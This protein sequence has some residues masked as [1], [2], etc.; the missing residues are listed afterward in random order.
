MTRGERIDYWLPVAGLVIVVAAWL[1]SPTPTVKAQTQLG[2]PIVVCNAINQTTA[3]L[4]AFTQTGCINRDTQTA[5]YITDI[6]ASATTIA[7]TTTDQYLVLKSGTGTNCGTG[8]V[9]LW[10]AYNLAFAGVAQQFK[11]P[12][13]VNGGQDLCWMDAVAGSKSFVVTGYLGNQ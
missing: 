1:L 11:T 13:K 2:G 6:V 7:T 12:L 10:A 9:I 4:I 5:L 3:T 8:T